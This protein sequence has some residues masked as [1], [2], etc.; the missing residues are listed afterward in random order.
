MRNQRFDDLG[1]VVGPGIRN[2]IL[3]H[4]FVPPGGWEA[5][6]FGQLSEKM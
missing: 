4:P 1:W 6:D 2:P 3:Y 5:T